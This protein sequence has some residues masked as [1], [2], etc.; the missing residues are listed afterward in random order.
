MHP[1]DGEVAALL[2]RVPD[3]L[4]AQPGPGGLRRRLLG[5]E[6]LQ[7]AGDPVD[8]PALLQQV[9]EAAAAAD[10][11]VGEVELGDPRVRQRQVVLGPVA[12]DQLVA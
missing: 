10:V 12:L 8:L 6:D 1:V 5:L 2:L 3:E 7:V 9:V 4:A 11:V